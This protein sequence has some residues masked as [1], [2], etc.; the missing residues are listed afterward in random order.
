MAYKILVPQYIP[1][2]GI[3]RLVELGCELCT[4]CGETQEELL[5][6][7]GDCDAVLA[8]TAPYTR[9]VIEAAKRLKIIARYG[10]GVD[11]ID[12]KAA[13]ELGIWVSNTPLSN[14][15]TV[16]EHTIGL[17]IS[18][19]RRMSLCERAFRQG[20]FGIR[21]QV[22]GIDLEGKTIGLIGLGRI[23]RLVAKKCLYGLDMRVIAYDPFLSPQQCPEGI[24]LMQDLDALLAG[25]DFVSVHLP[26]C[27]STRMLLG[28][29]QFERMKPGAYLINTARGE[30]V[31]EGALIHA[32]QT[33]QIA[34]AGLDVYTN[35]CPAADNPL[36]QLDNVT[37][38]P[39]N[40]SFTTEAYLRLGQHAA[41][42]VEEVLFQHQA[43]SWPVNHPQKPREG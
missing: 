8:R 37:L 19:A 42:C 20:N 25:A 35:E 2:D 34:G 6:A 5:E 38:T 7:I 9:R 18:V 32:L 17:L 29:A 13:E 39:H 31:D 23:G 1:A 4:G 36:F 10:V 22:T 3:Q 14:L 21:N 16:A 30:V 28:K 33:H 12:A 24:A 26:L 40:A 27:E 43:P 11:N 41:K 15:N